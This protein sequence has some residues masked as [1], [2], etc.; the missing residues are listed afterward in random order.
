MQRFGSDLSL[1][2]HPFHPD[3]ICE[4]A[5]ANEIFTE[6]G[7]WDLISTVVVIPVSYALPGNQFIADGG[8][9]QEYTEI[10]P[11]LAGGD[12]AGRWSYH[13][14]I[15]VVQRG[16][17]D[18]GYEYDELRDT[19]RPL[20]QTQHYSILQGS[21]YTFVITEEALL[22]MRLCLSVDPVRTSPR[23]VRNTTTSS[24]SAP[25]Q[26]HR[27]VVSGS[28]ISEAMSGLSEMSIDSVTKKK[29]VD[30]GMVEYSVVPWK[31]RGDG[32]TIKLALYCLVRLANE[33]NELQESYDS[34]QPPPVAPI[35]NAPTQ[36]QGGAKGKEVADP[37]G[38]GRQCK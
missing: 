19:V 8:Q 2:I 20:E 12:K 4:K 13:E 14:A 15:Q 23:P 24:T 6:N 31:G 36:Q 37:K 9:I 5:G 21:R 3:D 25:V 35:Q 27:R 34:L 38:K 11:D 30:V 29:G 1:P 18:L 22:V 7:L 33:A 28:T 16:S 32:L 26:S 10:F 17:D